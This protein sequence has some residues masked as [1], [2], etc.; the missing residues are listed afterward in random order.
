MARI[1]TRSGMPPQTFIRITEWAARV[2]GLM[3]AGFVLLFLVGNGFDPH[4]LT[5]STGPMFVALV[6]T[7]IGM[8]VLLRSRLVGGLMVVGGMAAFYLVEFAISGSLPGGWVFPL[9]FVPGVL[10]LVSWTLSRAKS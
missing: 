9:C 10:A 2:L 3:L 6:T 4:L 8:I 1:L 7:V 5:S